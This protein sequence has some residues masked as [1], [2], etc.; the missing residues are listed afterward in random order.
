MLRAQKNPGEGLFVARPA[1]HLLVCSLFLSLISPVFSQDIITSYAGGGQIAGPALSSLV[2]DPSGLARDAAGNLYVATVRG[3]VVLKINANGQLSTYAGTG[4]GGYAGD[5]GLA[6]S[7]QLAIPL[8]LALD[9]F[10]NLFIADSVYNIIRRV[11]ARSGIITTVAGNG[12]RGYAGDNGPATNASLNSP[13]GVSV[14]ALGNL[15]VADTQNSVIRRVDAVTGVITTI[16]GDFAGGGA[17]RGDGGPATAASLNGPHGIAVDNTGNLFLTDTGNFCVRRVDATTQTITTVAGQG[18]V[19]GDTGDGGPAASSTLTAPEA[20]FLD[21]SGNLFISDQQRIRGVDSATQIITTV[22]GSAK[23]GFTGDGGLA[24]NAELDR[25]VGIASDG[26]GN[27][28]FAD[29]SNNRIRAVNAQGIIQTIAGGGSGG[30]GGP[31]TSAVFAGSGGVA[32]TPSGDLLIGDF[33]VGRIRKVDASTGEISTVAG[34]GIR[35]TAGDGG[36]ATRAEMGFL[37]FLAMD[38]TGNAFLADNNTV[39]R[40]DAATQ[41]IATVVPSGVLSGLPNGIATDSSGVLYLSD[42]NKNVVDRVDP[43]TGALTVAAGT[44]GVSGY[45]G[46]GGPATN[47]TLDA[48]AGLA[49]DSADNL[50]I[51]DQIANVVRRVDNGT[52]VITTIAGTGSAGYSGDGGPAASAQLSLPFAVALDPFGNLFIGE[53]R[54]KRIRRVSGLTGRIS[55]VAGNGTSIFG[56]DGGSALLGGIGSTFALAADANGH[57]F[58]SDP[59][60]NRVREILL[61][62]QANLSVNILAFPATQVGQTSATQSTTLTNAGDG[63]MLIGGIAVIGPNASDFNQSNNCPVSPTSF[64]PGASCLLTLTFSPAGS[65]GESAVLQINDDAQGSPHTASLTGTGTSTSARFTLTVAP[66]S[67]GG[68]GATASVLPGRAATFTVILQPN[69]GFIGTI[70]ITC[71]SAIPS[72]VCSVQPASVNVNT[73]PSQPTALTITLQTNTVAH[74]AVERQPPSTS[75]SLPLFAA[76]NGIVPLALWGSNELRKGSRRRRFAV[77]WAGKSA[78]AYS[79]F[80]LVLALWL[81]GCGG[82]SYSANFNAPSTPPGTYQLPVVATA[83]GGVQQ[84]VNLTVQVL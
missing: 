78:L 27:L 41:N 22:A 31:A 37:L 69:P 18:Q 9:H 16:A 3:N 40:I 23:R 49:F 38:H 56:G 59:D 63:A 26:L 57:L 71:P 65:G 14:D 47:A 24:T 80:L 45:S 43:A 44:P 32:I 17:F 29:G 79:A 21:G 66:S 70:S 7:A 51:V 4:I 13:S 72:T 54:N 28:Y 15:F 5:G 62:P 20:V 19:A 6:S 75:R 77:R 34:N 60:F 81:T 42:P 76:I 33:S 36:P 11:E 82:N 48:P 64:P 67:N 73:T 61:A 12:T 35:D 8:G 1:C 46:D 55:T 68:S 50:F 10:G 58:Q 52:G 74:S 84:S 25:P 30:D 83:P 2:P 39:R 53:G